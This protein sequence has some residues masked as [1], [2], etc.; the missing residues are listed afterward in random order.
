MKYIVRL[1]VEVEPEGFWEK[2]TSWVFRRSWR[3]GIESK[4]LAPEIESQL[5]RYAES[6][7]DRKKVK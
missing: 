6:M 2:L 1:N 5:M 4:L 3:R 7:D